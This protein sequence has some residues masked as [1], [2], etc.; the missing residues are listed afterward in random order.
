MK[1]WRS[2]FIIFFI[3]CLLSLGL[4][5]PGEAFFGLPIPEGNLEG[6]LP[7]NGKELIVDRCVYL[8][9]HC[10]FQVAA[11]RSELSTRLNYIQTQLNR[12]KQI[13]DSPEIPEIQVRP[14]GDSDT[15]G[16][17]NNIEIQ[18]GDEAP[19][20][21][22][23]VTRWDA[24]LHGED[25]DS[26]TQQ[27]ID[28]IQ[29]ALTQAQR[30]RTP[31]YL[32]E[33]GAIAIGI[34]LLALILNLVG[35]RWRHRLYKRQQWAMEFPKTA[36]PIAT[37]LSQ[38]QSNNLQEVEMR[39][40]Q[41]LQGGAIAAALF[42]NLGLFPQT[43]I[44]Q[45]WLL[46]IFKY[47]LWLALIALVSYLSVRLSYALIAK[48][49]QLLADGALE[50][51]TFITQESNQRLELRVQTFSQVMRSIATLIILIIALLVFLWSINIDIA[52]ILA[53]AGIIGLAVSFAAQNLLKDIIN[54]F[55][56]I[57]EDQY[58][59]GDV[60]NVGAVTGLVENIN[61]RI[62]QIRDAEGRLITIPNGEVRIVANLSNQ[63]SR[64]DL[65]I[66]IPYNIDVDLALKVLGEVAQKMYEE[67]Q[68][69]SQI[70]E[71]PIVLGVDNFNER[72]MVIKLWIKTLPLKQW[73]VAR[74]FRRRLAIALNQAGIT[75][76]ALQNEVWLRSDVPPKLG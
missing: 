9:G 29:A 42:I 49:N 46:T 47:P 74:E 34:T 35:R 33:Q 54:G 31:E 73:E 72:G 53:G 68:W 21:L 57:L 60:I 27:L 25:I 32:K 75:I 65:N 13:Y 26:R 64:A 52:P 37:Q 51:F 30:E 41:L 61:L 14:V 2:P 76:P 23:T 16:A 48:V 22:M 40:S 11:P 17:Q 36:T 10:I 71:P 69:R 12:V 44:F 7:T 59:V 38:R 62:T 45:V 8:D 24:Q 19:F 50:A 3:T 39:L 66:P 56:I 43:R 70:I 63:W 55:S 58:A 6:I 67:K 5:R 18:V 1:S 28:Q 4:Q 20:R 15:P